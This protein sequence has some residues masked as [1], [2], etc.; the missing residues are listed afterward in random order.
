MKEF[1]LAALRKK[2]AFWYSWKVL[3]GLST[4]GWV[5]LWYM[6]VAAL[7]EGRSHDLMTSLDRAIPFVPWTWWIYFP[8]YLFGMFFTI[9]I[10][11]DDG[12]Y[13]RSV[14]A[15]ML[16]QVINSAIYLVL[17]STFPR[18]WD[19]QGAGLTADAIRWFW[20]IDPPNNTFPSSHV[21][22]AVIAA[23]ALWRDRHPLRIVPTLTAL[24]III[25]V[26][27]TKQHYWVDTLAGI[28]MAF[29]TT[30]FLFDFWPRLRARYFGAKPVPA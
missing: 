24:G 13:Y 2:G 6:P 28:A 14:A 11:R 21:T 20:T 5:S 29:L 7:T 12:I 9:V 27:T 22:L 8:G 10:I 15:I 16:A 18:P 30:H 26:H 4:V 25:T 19:W 23:L 1:F 3:V 17:P